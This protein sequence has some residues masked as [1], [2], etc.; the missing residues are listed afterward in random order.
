MRCSLSVGDVTALAE[1]TIPAEKGRGNDAW[2]L[3]LELAMLRSRITLDITGPGVNVTED[4]V[5]YNRR[6]HPT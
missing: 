2:R 6:S 3:E 1:R 5:G 4:V